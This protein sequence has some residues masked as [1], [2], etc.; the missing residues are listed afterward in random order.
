[1]PRALWPAGTRLVLVLLIAGC[2][3]IHGEPVPPGVADVS[4]FWDGTW[5]AGSGVG[6]GQIQLELK[7]S[8]TTVHGQVTIT[9]V[10]AISATDGRIE[11]QVVGN[12]F[13]FKQP[14]GVL[15]G[16][17]EANGDE[18]HGAATGLLRMALSLRRVPQ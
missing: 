2:T 15:E 17:L 14:A 16:K 10:T 8:A 18:L 11:G 6:H 7:Q 12:V 3:L 9:G 13:T 4:G 1:M 5:D